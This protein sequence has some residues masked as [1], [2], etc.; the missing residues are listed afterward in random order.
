MRQE[1][2]T[3]DNERQLVC[4]VL[5]QLGRSDLRE[6]ERF[7][8][9]F[10]SVAALR[11]ASQ[12]QCRQYVSGDTARQALLTAIELGRWAQR[13]PRP[14]YGTVVASHQIAESLMDDLRYRPQERLEALILDARHQVIERQTVF[15]GT[16]DSCP[17]HP[18]EIFRLAVLAGGAAIVVAHNHPSGQAKPSTNDLAFMRRL[19]RCGQ[20]MG[21]PLLDGF[22]IGLRSY[23]SLREAE[24]LPLEQTV[25]QSEGL[26]SD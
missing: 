13:A 4:R 16:L 26:K 9:Y 15:V 3:R 22:V 11:Y 2:V 14:I 5:R 18:R 21:I 24:M 19:A 12:R 10:H 6:V 8:R 23:F 25:N 17:V 7:F 1:R 20:L